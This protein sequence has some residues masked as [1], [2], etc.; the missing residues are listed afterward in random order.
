MIEPPR[1]PHLAKIPWPTSSRCHRTVL[2]PIA[3]SCISTAA[4]TQPQC[5]S[6]NRASRSSAPSRRRT[7]RKMNAS[8]PTEKTSFSTKK[9][10]RLG[11][12]L[13]S[14][15]ASVN[16]YTQKGQIDCPEEEL[17]RLVAPRSDGW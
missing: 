6:L 9:A 16:R 7:F 10:I 8:I 17:G 1:N 3:M 13:T 11:V 15:A 12:A 2:K 5:K 14:L 4:T